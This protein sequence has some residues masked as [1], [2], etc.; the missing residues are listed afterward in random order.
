MDPRACR[1]ARRHA[2]AGDI[3]E[4]REIDRRFASLD[5]LR[6]NR[7]R[8]RPQP[9]R[10][11]LPTKP[12]PSTP[13][14]A[15]SFAPARWSRGRE[16]RRDVQSGEE[17]RYETWA[18]TSGR[19]VRRNWPTE[20]CAGRLRCA[21]R[22]RRPISSL[23]ALR[24]LG[25][26]KRQSLAAEEVTKQIADLQNSSRRP[27]R[28]TTAERTLRHGHRAGE[29][30]SRCGEG[31]RRVAA[32]GRAAQSQ[33][34]A[35][36]NQRGA[37]DADRHARE[38]GVDASAAVRETEN[39][40][41]GV[42]TEDVEKS[43]ADAMKAI[44]DAQGR[45]VESQL[46][47]LDAGQLNARRS[48]RKSRPSRRDRSSTGSSSSAKSRGSTRSGRTTPRTVRR[49]LR[50]RAVERKDDAADRVAVQ[51]GEPLAAR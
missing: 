39:V 2:I 26:L 21:C 1:A 3:S 20:R 23:Q 19:S 49:R 14:A 44:D 27:T 16:L 30:Q 43:R 18:G 35:L 37:G 22:R 46:K 40:D 31:S 6:V 11:R 32:E 5:K 4:G 33:V 25:D 47:Q 7:L 9:R 17:A 12:P 41:M 38:K 34:A 28:C 42:E 29:G 36:K 48:S 13:K 51:P 10:R 8:P 45:I 50:I 24:P 15:R